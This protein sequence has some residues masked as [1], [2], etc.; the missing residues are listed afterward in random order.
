[1]A[2]LFTRI[3]PV[4][5]ERSNTANPIVVTTKTAHG[6]NT[7]DRIIISGH[8]INTNVNGVYRVTVIN[9]TSFS[10]PIGSKGQEGFGGFAM[11]VISNVPTDIS[12]SNSIQGTL[13][14]TGSANLSIAFY[15][16]KR[17]VY[18]LSETIP[19]N[20]SIDV[21]GSD[22]GRRFLIDTSSV[23]YVYP[24]LTRWTSGS[25]SL[26][27]SSDGISSTEDY[28]A[29]DKLEAF[30]NK[31]YPAKYFDPSLG[32]DTGDGSIISPY[33]DLTAAR[34]SPGYRHL[35]K[36]GTTIT[37]STG[38][39][40]TIPA[41]GTE[42]A[43]I[44]IGRYG[45]KLAANP[46]IDNALGNRAIRGGTS[47]TNWRVRDLDII[48]PGAGADRYGISQNSLSATTDSKTP[49]NILI[50]RCTVRTVQTDSSTDCDGIKLY[51][52]DNKI[53]DCTIRNI[54]SDGIWFHGYRMLVM[55]CTIYSVAEDG[56][57]IGDCIQAGADS[58]GSIIRGNNLDHRNADYKQCIYFEETN[59][60]SSYVTIEDNV[61]Y[62]YEGATTGNHTPILCGAK[63][64]ICRRNFASGGKQS[65]FIGESSIGHHNVVYS[66]LAIGM[67]LSLNS[68]AYNNTL[69]QTGSDTTQTNSRGINAPD[70]TATGSI[71]KNNII[72]GYYNSI[73]TVAGASGSPVVSE[74]YNVFYNPGTSKAYLRV[75]GTVTATTNAY[76]VP[77][78]GILDLDANYKPNS[79][80]P[81]FRL[82]DAVNLTGHTDKDQISI[83][84]VN[85][86][87]AYVGAIQ[88]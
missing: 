55:G 60:V 61:A 4:E 12:K 44:I 66:P 80:S 26:Q 30:E 54:A 64:S 33:R 6:Y 50:Q 88:Y 31:E 47:A 86:A 24:V 18:K 34:L 56:R 37:T 62:G 14:T 49:Y 7:G 35:I 78:Q 41:T 58:T 19:L 43:P 40:L 63:F 36:A 21:V 53:I 70:S 67:T 83:P 38:T 29:L 69:V 77:N 1:M 10:I 9:T 48:G 45:D 16:S 59:S 32:A 57:N 79:T 73:Y 74:S 81:V 87:G 75:D 22:I 68:E 2:T 71:A 28:A 23:N 51:G 25:I 82:G 46:I 52:A 42:Q 15:G 76:I 72:I 85:M 20:Y 5:I 27:L 3:T 11:F 84:F 65:I 8:N 13:R 39:W 17:P